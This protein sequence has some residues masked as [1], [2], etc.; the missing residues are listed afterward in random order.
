C[1]DT[2]AQ[3]ASTYPPKANTKNPRLVPRRGPF[4][5]PALSDRHFRHRYS[6]RCCY[7][8]AVIRI[9]FVAVGDVANHDMALHPVH[10]PRRVLEQ[11]LLLVCRHQTEQVAR[12]GEV[13]VIFLAVIVTGCRTFQRHRRLAE[14]GLLLPFAI[15]IRL[16][17]QAAALVAIDPHGTIAVI[18]VDRATGRVY[19]DL[20]V[21]HT[22]TVALRIAVGEQTPL[23]HAIRREADAGH[24]VGRGEGSLLHILEVVVRIAVELHVAHLDQRV[25]LLRPDLGQIERMKAIGSS[26]FLGHDLHVHGPAREVTVLDRLVQVPLRAFAV[27]GHDGGC[28]R[29]G[30]ILDA[31]LGLEVELDPVALLVGTDEAVGV[32][33]EQVH[34]TVAC[35]NT[36]VTHHVGDLVQRFG[37]AGPEVP[38]VVGTAHVGAR[39]AFYRV[40]QVREFQRIA[41]EEDRGVVAHQVPVTLLGVE[42]QGCTTDV[43]L[44]I[45]RATFTGDGGEAGEHRGLLPDFGEDPGLGVF[46]DVVGNNKLTKRTGALGVHTTLGNHFAVE[47]SQLFQ[48][49]YVLQQHGAALAGGHYVLVLGYWRAGYCS[50]SWLVGH[51]AR[52]WSIRSPTVSEPVACGDNKRNMQ[53]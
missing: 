22:Q 10:G 31:L 39:V 51:I 50:E 15:S 32:R 1:T 13:V 6:Q 8:F 21:V 2:P 44:G 24:H 29:V 3:A 52:S 49:P 34:M 30:Q 45:G 9:G 11:T 36:P 28:F 19:R 25:V 20:V 14:I 40:V 46:A 4:Q 37:Q 33:T 42:L 12:L 47:V 48:E 18:A 17:M 27:I 38:V 41:E 5:P 16:V 43:T 35:G 26:L 7:T 53:I 23:Q